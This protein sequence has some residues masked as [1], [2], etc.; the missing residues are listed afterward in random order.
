MAGCRIELLSDILLCFHVKYSPTRWWRISCIV[1]TLLPSGPSEDF[2]LGGGGGGAGETPEDLL[3]SLRDSSPT[4]LSSIGKRFLFKHNVDCGGGTLREDQRDPH[5]AVFLAAGCCCCVSNN[6]GALSE[7]LKPPFVVSVI[8]S[9]CPPS[10]SLPAPPPPPPRSEDPLFIP[11]RVKP[12]FFLSSDVFVL[13]G[14]G[15]GSGAEVPAAGTL[16]CGADLNWNNFQH[17][18]QNRCLPAN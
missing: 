8:Q 6:V 3:G 13:L 7:K 4:H 14:G 9:D 12:F 2:I 18:S 10:S 11:P 16:F 15:L 5:N 17:T 1:L